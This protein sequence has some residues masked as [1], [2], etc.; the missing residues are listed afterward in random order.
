MGGSVDISN[1]VQRAIDNPG[2]EPEVPRSKFAVEIDLSNAAF[3]EGDQPWEMGM[4]VARLLREVA[5]LMYGGTHPRT[6]RLHDVN[7][8]DVGTAEFRTE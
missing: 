4:E 3:G 5:D 8:N 6:F 1:L 7:G 2:T